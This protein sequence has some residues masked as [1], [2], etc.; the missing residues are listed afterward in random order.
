[1]KR[2]RW[3]TTLILSLSI[4]LIIGIITYNILS[5]KNKLTS[6]ERTWID[7]NINDVQNVY[8]IKDEN[9]FSKDGTGIFYNFLNDFK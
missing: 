8:V 5:D 4:I 1:M 3:I 9:I 6:E 2:N 7:Q